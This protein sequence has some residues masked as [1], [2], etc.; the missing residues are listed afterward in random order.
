MTEAQKLDPDPERSPEP[1]QKEASEPRLT[2]ATPLFHSLHDQMRYKIPSGF[3]PPG[4]LDSSC[5]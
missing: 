5:A 1:E 2:T 4:P 3:V